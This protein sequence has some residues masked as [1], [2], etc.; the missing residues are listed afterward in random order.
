MFSVGI[1]CWLSV[2]IPHLVWPSQS[3]YETLSVYVG[4]V[5]FKH[6][7][8]LVVAGIRER[9]HLDGGPIYGFTRLHFNDGSINALL[10]IHEASVVPLGLRWWHEGIFHPE[11][12]PYT[13]CAH[14]IL[15][16]HSDGVV[17]VRGQAAGGLLRKFE[18]NACEDEQSSCV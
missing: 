12:I 13:V 5:L 9:L 16:V 10:Q 14:D 3:S 17:D 18:N 15:D 2:Q 8:V 11:G 6:S 7:L 1:N 4:S